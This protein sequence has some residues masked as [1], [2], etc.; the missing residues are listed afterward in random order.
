MAYVDLVSTGLTP[1][2]GGQTYNFSFDSPISADGSPHIT[3]I[4]FQIEGVV[5]AGAVYNSGGIGNLISNYRIKIGADTLLN[6]D[7]TEAY[8]AD[9]ATQSNLSCLAAKVGGWDTC[10][11][12]AADNF[13]GEITLPF[14]L[15][16]SRSHRVNISITLG[17]ETNWCGKPFDVAATQFNIVNFY[18]TAKDSTLY[19]SRQDFTLTTG[20]QRTLTCYGKTGW[21][22]LGVVYLNN[23]AADVVSEIR[24]NN[25]SFRALTIQQWR[26]LDST[27]T[28]GIQDTKPDVFTWSAVTARLGFLFLD[29]KRLTAGADISM[30]FTATADSTAS[31]YPVWVAPLSQ[32]T[33]TPVRQ[34]QNTV[35]STARD[36]E[37]ES[38]F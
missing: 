20:S 27:Y 29:L 5:G 18:G 1:V 23:T 8:S 4:G 22:M 26:V 6:F 35:S 34:T 13:V 10:Q 7:D 3:H 33:S 16:A 12:S 17:S 31:L 28:Q 15:D 32:S 11:E 9:S 19:G 2:Q 37:A 24:P 30:A 14:G 25:G 38:K 36:V 21:N